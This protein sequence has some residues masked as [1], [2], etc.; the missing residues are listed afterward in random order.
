M[1]DEATVVVELDRFERGAVLTA[2]ND[3]RTQLLEQGRPTDTVNEAIVK[4]AL[5]PAKK[6]RDRHEAR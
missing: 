2:L 6:R 1:S 5:A 3:E 4:V